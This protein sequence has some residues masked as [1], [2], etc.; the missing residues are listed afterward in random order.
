MYF[1]TKLCQTATRPKY[2]QRLEFGQGKGLIP[3][4]NAKNM[5]GAQLSSYLAGMLVVYGG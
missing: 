5:Y 2:D 4:L 1:K 3:C